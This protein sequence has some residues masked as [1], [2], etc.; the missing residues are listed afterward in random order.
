[1]NLREIVLFIEFHPNYI[2]T[3]IIS[4]LMEIPV[5]MQRN[6]IVIYRSF[7]TTGNFFISRTLPSVR[8]NA[9][10]YGKLNIWYI[11]VLSD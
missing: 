9:T 1:M 5:D 3:L 11:V 6:K 4:E 2:L 7:M 8:F 10:G